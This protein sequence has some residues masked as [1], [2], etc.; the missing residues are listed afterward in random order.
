MSIVSQNRSIGAPWKS[1]EGDDTTNVDVIAIYECFARQLGDW[2]L[3]FTEFLLAT[4]RD[5]T[6]S[7]LSIRGG[8]SCPGEEGGAYVLTSWLYHSA[9]S[10]PGN[11]RNV[12]FGTGSWVEETVSLRLT[13]KL[14]Y[15][16]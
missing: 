1:E 12:R 4:V 5:R 7:Q 6:K 13:A 11:M 8:M 3:S 10:C 2:L 15:I 9:V 16:Y 14:P